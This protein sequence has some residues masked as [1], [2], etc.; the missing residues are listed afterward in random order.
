MRAQL[1]PVPVLVLTRGGYDVDIRFA[2]NRFLLVV[3][4]IL[5]NKTLGL[6][7]VDC[8][9]VTEGSLEFGECCDG[10]RHEQRNDKQGCFLKRLI[11]SRGDR[12]ANGGKKCRMT[13]T[14]N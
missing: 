2:K 12:R 1:F 8:T 14:S 4:L 5:A 6:G 11:L 3:V 9:T 10:G 13:E 7:V